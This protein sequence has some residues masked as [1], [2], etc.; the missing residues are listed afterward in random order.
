MRM[1]IDI[2]EGNHIKT[3]N[4]RYSGKVFDLRI[5]LTEIYS[6]QCSNK[7]IDKKDNTQFI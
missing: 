1:I 2:S 7:N 3:N 5:E 4:K 6:G